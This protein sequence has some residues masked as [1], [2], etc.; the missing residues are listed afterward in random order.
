MP[1]APTKA[2]ARRCDLDWLRVLAVLLLVPFHSALIFALDPIH[3]VY[4]KDRV[5]SPTLIAID[6][7]IYMWHMPL[8]FLIAGA[9]TWFAL[10]KRTAGEYA[11]ERFL[12]LLVP[13]LFGFATLIPFMT[14]FH[15]FGKAGALSFWQA[16]PRFFTLNMNDLGGL[17]GT[18]TPAHLWF[19]LFLFV[20]SLLAIP[21]FFYLRRDASQRAIDRIAKWFNLPGV[22]LLVAIPLALLTRLPGLA[23]KNPF[24]FF[25]LF[26]IGFVLMASPRFQASIDRQ[27]I[28]LLI[29]AIAGSLFFY[30][31]QYDRTF[32]RV[33]SPAWLALYLVYYVSVWSWLLAFVGLAHKFLNVSNAFLRYASEAAYPFYILHLPVNTVVGYFA[34]QMN[35]NI[36]VKYAIINVATILL[37]V[38]VYDVLVKRTRVTRFLFGMKPTRETAKVPLRPL[39]KKPA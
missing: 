27:A 7:F 6:G 10:G 5:E 20:F 21:V 29:V 14:Y 32:S 38:A 28:G 25:A 11:R 1:T 13:A 34:V 3:M 24:Y 35:A 17:N 30:A 33:N 23:D 8:L 2:S 39:E 37:T 4:I 12:R 18:F 16:Y 26:V 19:I 36:G 22:I 9:A 31:F 15:N